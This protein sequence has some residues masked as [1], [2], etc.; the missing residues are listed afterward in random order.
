VLTCRRLT[1]GAL[2][3]RQIQ[4][5]LELEPGTPDD[6]VTFLLLVP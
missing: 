6:W 4:I 2:S 5:L 3:N 1:A